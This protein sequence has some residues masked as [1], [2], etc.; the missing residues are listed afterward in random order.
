MFSGFNNSCG[1]RAQ[2]I[3]QNRKPF[4][5][6]ESFRGKKLTEFLDDEQLLNTTKWS[7]LEPYPQD[8]KDYLLF[9]DER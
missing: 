8:V 1:R 4:P 7:L 5:G 3:I 2:R 6:S 9:S